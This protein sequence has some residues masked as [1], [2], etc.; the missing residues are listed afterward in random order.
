MTAAGTVAP[1]VDLQQDL[2]YPTVWSVNDAKGNPVGVVGTW[3]RL[4]MT[5]DMLEDQPIPAKGM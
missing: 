4:M 3:S 1:T 5:T 2:L